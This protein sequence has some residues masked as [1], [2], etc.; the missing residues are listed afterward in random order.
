[1]EVVVQAG[2]EV[3]ALEVGDRPFFETTKGRKGSP[4]TMLMP[5]LLATSFQSPEL[6]VSLEL[7]N[8]C[9]P[10]SSADSLLTLIVAE[11]GSSDEFI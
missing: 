7:A 3:H 9:K 8:S 6:C 4:P 11:G 5:T 10:E 1:M 2:V